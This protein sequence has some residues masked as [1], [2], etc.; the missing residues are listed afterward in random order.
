MASPKK[1]IFRQDPGPHTDANA[2][3]RPGTKAAPECIPP[4]FTLGTDED[5]IQH[6]GG[7]VEA[8][9]AV[10]RA[11]DQQ[12]LRLQEADVDLSM[13]ATHC[14]PSSRIIPRITSE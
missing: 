10:V 8:P 1:T 6:P 3:P 11:S 4:L 7:Q 9:N 14:Y 12:I 5:R 2:A 13:Q